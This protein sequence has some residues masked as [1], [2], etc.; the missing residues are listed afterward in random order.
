VWMFGE[1]TKTSNLVKLSNTLYDMRL[2]LTSCW[3]KFPRKDQ[4][5]LQ[6]QILESVPSKTSLPREYY[7]VMWSNARRRLVPSGYVEWCLVW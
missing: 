7:T 6:K 5:T 1:Q 2:V 4:N 3:E